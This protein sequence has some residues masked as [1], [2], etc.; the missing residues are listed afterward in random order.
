MAKKR[1][2]TG[3]RNPSHKKSGQASF[4]KITAI[5]A[6][7]FSIALV[8]KIVMTPGPAQRPLV[9]QTAP[10]TPSARLVETN[11]QLV[12]SEFECACGHCGETPLTDC[13][14]DRPRGGLEEKG[15]IRQK[16]KQGRSVEETI[17]LLDKKYGHRI[18]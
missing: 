18:T 5:L 9:P 15:F 14:C 11:V 17:Q 12:A 1:S 13:S 8:A 6:V 3:K 4:W 16:L 2:R 7:L 10:L